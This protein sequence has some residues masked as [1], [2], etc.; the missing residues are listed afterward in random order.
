M[1]RCTMHPDPCWEGYLKQWPTGSIRHPPGEAQGRLQRR[2]GAG[3]Q[4]EE[5][6]N[7]RMAGEESARRRELVLG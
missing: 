2:V 7:R 4:G 1:F 5:S 3:A 6:A